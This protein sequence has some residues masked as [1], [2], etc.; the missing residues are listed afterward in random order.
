MA[1]MTVYKMPK[2]K[3]EVE[4]LE[5]EDLVVLGKMLV[6][7]PTQ[8]RQVV[9]IDNQDRTVY[10]GSWEREMLDYSGFKP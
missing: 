10:R 1:Q 7:L 5:T 9:V 6:N 8:V 4:S 2:G 3:I